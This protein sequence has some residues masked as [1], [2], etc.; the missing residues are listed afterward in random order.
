MKQIATLLRVPRAHHK[1]VDNYGA[2]DFIEKCND[3]I[4][5]NDTKRLR[6]EALEER[7]RIRQSFSVDRAVKQMAGSRI[8]IEI[9]QPQFHR[10]KNPARREH[11]ESLHD[12]VN[13]RRPGERNRHVKI[14]NAK[15]DLYWPESAVAHGI[16][17]AMEVKPLTA[18]YGM[19]E[20]MID[21]IMERNQTK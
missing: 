1:Y 20:K 16:S 5:Y 19:T 9:P 4:D 6:Q 17:Q 7:A 18:D 15:V 14:D 10:I 3:I 12:N 21:A 13:I 11:Y 8:Q 2:F